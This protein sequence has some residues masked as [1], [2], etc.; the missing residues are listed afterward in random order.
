MV[1]GALDR[2][3]CA[4]CGKMGHWAKGCW[5]PK[6]GGKGGKEGSSKSG[7]RGFGKGSK[8]YGKSGKGKGGGKFNGTCNCCFRYGHKETECRKK[9]SDSGKGNGGKNVAGVDESVAGSSGSVG[10]VNL[11]NEQP[12]QDESQWIM[13]LNAMSVNSG[14]GSQPST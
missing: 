5:A 1:V 9:A 13:S 12:Q 8:D 7:K 2:D 4:N 6:D 10:A 14:D 3:K 11:Y